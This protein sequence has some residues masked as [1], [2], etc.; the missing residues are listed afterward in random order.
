MPSARAIARRCSTRLVDPPSTIPTTI[1]LPNAFRVTMSR[2]LKVH[3]QQLVD[4][5]A[6]AT[7]SSSLAGSSAGVDDEY[8]RLIPMPRWGWPSCWRCTFRRTPQRLGR[9]GER[10]LRCPS[11]ISPDSHSPIALKCG[12]RYRVAYLPPPKCVK[13]GSDGPAIHHDRRPIQPSHRHQT[14]RHVLVAARQRRSAPSY[15]CA[16]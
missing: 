15:H 4:C 13:P 7:H 5:F 8:G 16:P 14:A 10:S 12:R 11:L 9:R 6:A 3:F 1:A 2:G